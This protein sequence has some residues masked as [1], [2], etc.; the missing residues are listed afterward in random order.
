[1][2]LNIV[3]ENCIEILV[4]NQNL[5]KLNNLHVPVELVLLSLVL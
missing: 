2:R 5:K 4:T 3:K 1:M